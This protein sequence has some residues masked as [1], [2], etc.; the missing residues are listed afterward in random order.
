MNQLEIDLHNY[1]VNGSRIGSRLSSS[2]PFFNELKKKDVVEKPQLG[3]EIGR[4]GD[5]LDYILIAV[6]KFKGSL[7]FN[8][9]PAFVATVNDVLRLY[10]EPFWQDSSDEELIFFY[11]FENGEIEIQFEFPQ[12]P[13]LAFIT[14]AADG[15]MSDEM[16]RQAYG[17]DKQWPPE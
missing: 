9:L 13:L 14:I 4:K 8:G 16:Q 1:E 6:Q 12:E 3:F 2:A 7:T 15:I 17:V 11:E 10:G 5:H